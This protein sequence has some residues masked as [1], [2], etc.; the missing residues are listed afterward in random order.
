MIEEE[1][2]PEADPK[3]D[4]QP[5]ASEPEA[6]AAEEPEAPAAEEPAAEPAADAGP[7]DEAPP[8]VEPPAQES[9]APAAESGAETLGPKERRRRAR[10]RSEGPARPQRSPDE[11]ASER[12]AA[13]ARKAAER[14]RWRGKRRERKPETPGPAAQAPARDEALA[15]SRQKVR[16]GV[17]VGSGADKTITVRIDLKR[18]HRVYGKVV[19]DSSTLHVHDES[20]QAGEGDLVRV[21]ECRPLSRTKRWRLVEVVEK[22]R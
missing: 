11:R 21:I 16:Q 19:R 17:V 22:A 12:I 20:N 13:R 14:R 7:A 3:A 6:P 2:N 10:S 5:E 18:Q 8:A 4:S 15:E 9:P 1:K